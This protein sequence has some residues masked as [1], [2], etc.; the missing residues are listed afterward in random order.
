MKDGG[1]GKF[2]NVDQELAIAGTV[3]TSNVIK[4]RDIQT[5][6]EDNKIFSKVDISA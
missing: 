5:I 1:R 2:L 6:V 3:M 4:L